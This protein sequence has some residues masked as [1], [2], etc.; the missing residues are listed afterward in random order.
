[1][2]FDNS[3]GVTISAKSNVGSNYTKFQTLNFLCT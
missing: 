3:K 2:L 1:M